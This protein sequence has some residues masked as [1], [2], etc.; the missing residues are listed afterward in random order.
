MISGL[1]RRVQSLVMFELDRINED[2][3]R[4]G[5]GSQSVALF[6]VDSVGGMSSQ[7]TVD[8]LV[9]LRVSDQAASL[10]VC[11]GLYALQLRQR[12]LTKHQP[13]LFHALFFIE[14]QP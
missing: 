7:K 10:T 11:E 13:Q 1:A 14:F 2:F 9:L 12:V 8:C 6:V 3:L 5:E 4:A